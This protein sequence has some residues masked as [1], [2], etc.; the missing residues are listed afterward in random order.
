M[1]WTVT[2][3]D[4]L[5][6]PA[7]VEPWQRCPGATRAWPPYAG[8]TT[9][10]GRVRARLIEIFGPDCILC[11]DIGRYVDHDHDSGLVRGL[12]CERCNNLVDWCPHT[13]GCAY[14]DYLDHP[15]AVPLGIR[16]PSRGRVV[17]RPMPTAAERAARRAEHAARVLAYRPV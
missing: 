2:L 17:V 16:Y 13:I 11:G 3:F 10:V 8:S 14:G 1:N 15:P 6:T 9:P 4:E 12:L 7:A 5:L